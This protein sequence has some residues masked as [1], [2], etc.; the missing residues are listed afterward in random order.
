MN[1]N[2]IH[3][4][5]LSVLITI[6][7]VST[8]IPAFAEETT[9]TFTTETKNTKTIPTLLSGCAGMVDGLAKGIVNVVAGDI[10]LK[11]IIGNKIPGKW[12]T[13]LC[14]G[15]CALATQFI[16][17]PLIYEIKKSIDHLRGK[18]NNTKYEDTAF[19][20]GS[21]VTNILTTVFPPN[22]FVTYFNILRKLK[23]LKKGCNTK[24]WNWFGQIKKLLGIK[25]PTPTIINEVQ[26]PLKL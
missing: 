5:I 14:R 11:Q 3:K 16:L 12:E 15:G 22:I 18:E 13:L 10:V 26:D 17:F 25:K 24:I 8:C 4:C 2:G 20:V 7:P 6:I 19:K 23:N 1:K 21:A 9:T